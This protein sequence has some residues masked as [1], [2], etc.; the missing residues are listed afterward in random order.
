M[1]S[2]NPRP[3]KK[4]SGLIQSMHF[5]AVYKLTTVGDKTG[6]KQN[7]KKSVKLKSNYDVCANILAFNFPSMKKN[8]QAY[9]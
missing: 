7:A 9:L 2:Q 4:K 5:H 6:Q 8:K 1:F 3:L